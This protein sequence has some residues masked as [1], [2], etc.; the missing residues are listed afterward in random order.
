MSKQ[1]KELQI[2]PGTNIRWEQ[3]YGIGREDHWCLVS[4][5]S[6]KDGKCINA[7][8]V[9]FSSCAGDM[10]GKPLDEQ[11]DLALYADAHNT[12][13]T[14]KKLPSALLRE[15]DE[16]IDALKRIASDDHCHPIINGYW[17][18]ASEWQARRDIA[19]D[20]LST[21]GSNTEAK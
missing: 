18:A 13:N 15:R 21:Q 12:Y 17:D 4:D 16:A 8:T 20:F 6:E 14:C 19:K 7:Y 10:S 2:T 5:E 11:P 1:T 9:L 3:S